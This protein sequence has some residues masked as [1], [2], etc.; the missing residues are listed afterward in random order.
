MPFRRDKPVRMKTGFPV[1]RS[2]RVAMLMGL[3]A[4]TAAACSRRENP[5]LLQ[6]RSS[7]EG[8]DEFSIVPNKPLETPE[9]FAYLPPPT[10]TGSSRADATPQ[11]DVFVA[12]GGTATAA[13]ARSSESG[14]LPYATR[15]GRSP[16]IREELAA[17]DLD[18]R[19]RNDVLFLERIANVSKY[20]SVYALES[21]DQDAE[22][23]RFRA[24]GVP[25]PAA[26]PPPF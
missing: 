18:F 9:D 2:M 13:N 17:S 11:E 3:I 6:L 20:F 7:G 4:L 19:R 8:P 1:Y 21:L 23:E 15:F 14:V 26:P 22:L 10:S 24:A 5:E 16:T 25:T 12:L